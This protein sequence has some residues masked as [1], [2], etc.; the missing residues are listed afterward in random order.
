MN[1]PQLSKPKANDNKG[2]KEDSGRE[3]KLHQ[4]T[5][6]TKNLGR[7]QAQWWASSF[8]AN[9]RTVNEFDS[10][11]KSDYRSEVRLDWN[12]QNIVSSWFQLT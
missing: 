4:V 5:E 3:P 6:W 12:N 7:N 9:E 1:C 10:G 8:L 11:Q 2:V